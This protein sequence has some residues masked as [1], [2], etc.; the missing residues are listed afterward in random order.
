MLVVVEVLEEEEDV[1]WGRY[2]VGYLWCQVGTCHPHQLTLVSTHTH[3]HIRAHIHII[4]HTHI[5]FT[6]WVAICWSFSDHFLVTG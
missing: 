1:Y 6:A 3:T 2:I 4:R 5:M